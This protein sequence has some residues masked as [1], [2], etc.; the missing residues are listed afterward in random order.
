M[1]VRKQPEYVLSCAEILH[2]ATIR[3]HVKPNFPVPL[4]SPGIV[5]LSAPLKEFL[6]SGPVVAHAGWPPERQRVA[7]IERFDEMAEAR[8]RLYFE[9]CVAPRPSAGRLVSMV[10]HKL[11]PAKILVD[12]QAISY[13]LAQAT[14]RLFSPATSYAVVPQLVKAMLANAQAGLCSVEDEDI[15]SLHRC[16]LITTEIQAPLLLAAKLESMLKRMELLAQKRL[17]R[18]RKG[19]DDKTIQG[20]LTAVARIRAAKHTSV[21]LFAAYAAAAEEEIAVRAAYSDIMSAIS[22]DL[23]ALYALEDAI[24]EGVDNVVEA[25][26]RADAFDQKVAEVQR[27]LKFTEDYKSAETLC[28]FTSFATGVHAYMAKNFVILGEYG[29]HMV[30]LTREQ[31]KQSVMLLKEAAACAVAQWYAGGIELVSA[32]KSCM[33]YTWSAMSRASYDE[34]NYVTVLQREWESFAVAH[35]GDPH[36]PAFDFSKHGNYGHYIQAWDN[37]AVVKGAR[38]VERAKAIRTLPQFCFEPLTVMNEHARCLAIVENQPDF[39]PQAETLTPALR[40]VIALYHRSLKGEMPKC[41]MDAVAQLDETDQSLVAAGDP[42]DLGHYRGIRWAGEGADWYTELD[43]AIKD[44][45]NVPPYDSMVTQDGAFQALSPQESREILYYVDH[46][47]AKEHEAFKASLLRGALGTLPVR[48]T[49]KPEQ[50]EGGRMIHMEC[51]PVRRANSIIQGNVLPVSQVF[52]GS[53]MGRSGAAKLQTMEKALSY[54]HAARSSGLGVLFVQTDFKKFGHSIQRDLTQLVLSEMAAYFAQPWMARFTDVLAKEV[55]A[56]TYGGSTVQFDNPKMADGQGLRNAVW[57]VLLLAIVYGS[58]AELKR[59]VPELSPSHPVAPLFFMDDH[60]LVFVY[61]KTPGM[62]PGQETEA[63][64]RKIMPVLDRIYNHYHLLLEPAKTLMSDNSFVL[65]GDIYTLT[66][67]HPTPTKGAANGLAPSD[68]PVPSVGDCLADVQSSMMSAVNTGTHPTK[69]WCVALIFAAIRIWDFSPTIASGFAELIAAILFM[70]REHGGFAFPLPQHLNIGTNFVKDIDAMWLEWAGMSSGSLMGRLM[71][72]ILGAPSP[73]SAQQRSS[74]VERVNNACTTS[75]LERKLMKEMAGKLSANI[76]EM[77]KDRDAQVHDLC[78]RVKECPPTL[79]AFAAGLHPVSVLI[80]KLRKVGKN[81]TMRAL[82]PRA[83]IPRLR[84][85][86]RQK[87]ASHLKGMQA[88]IKETPEKQI[89]FMG[90]LRWAHHANVHLPVTCPTRYFALPVLPGQVYG[91]HYIQLRTKE[92]QSSAMFVIG[93]APQPAPVSVFPMPT[94]GHISRIVNMHNGMYGHSSEFGEAARPLNARL[95]AIA[96][97]TYDPGAFRP[98]GN[99]VVYRD[100]P[101]LQYST[102]ATAAWVGPTLATYGLFHTDAGEI[103]RRHDCHYNYNLVML[104]ALMQTRTSDTFLMGRAALWK[105]PDITIADPGKPRDRFSEADPKVYAAAR[106]INEKKQVRSMTAKEAEDKQ[107]RVS[108]MMVIESRIHLDAARRLKEMAKE[109]ALDNHPFVAEQR[110]FEVV[111][112]T[113]VAELAEVKPR[114]ASRMLF[115]SWVNAVYMTLLDKGVNVQAALRVFPKVFNSYNIHDWRTQELLA[116]LQPQEELIEYMVATARKCRVYDSMLNWLLRMWASLIRGPIPREGLTL[117]GALKLSCAKCPGAYLNQMRLCVQHVN[118]GVADGLDSRL[119]HQ[120]LLSW[121]D[122][123]KASYRERAEMWRGISKQTDKTN[124]PRGATAVMRSLVA[125]RLSAMVYKK[126]SEHPDCLKSVELYSAAVN[127]AVQTEAGSWWKKLRQPACE[128]YA[129]LVQLGR[130]GKWE[131]RADALEYAI[132]ELERRLTLTRH[133]LGFDLEMSVLDMNFDPSLHDEALW[134]W[135]GTTDAVTFEGLDALAVQVLLAKDVTPATIG[136]VEKPADWKPED[137]RSIS[138]SM[139]AKKHREYKD[140]INRIAHGLV[141]G[142]LARDKGGRAA[143]VSSDQRP[144]EGRR[145]EPAVPKPAR[146]PKKPPAPNESPPRSP[147]PP[148]KPPPLPAVTIESVNQAIREREAALASLVPSWNRLWDALGQD[149]QDAEAF[150]QRRRDAN[151]EMITS[152]KVPAQNVLDLEELALRLTTRARE[153][154]MARN[155]EILS[156]NTDQPQAE[157][158]GAQPEDADA[159]GAIEENKTATDEQEEEKAE[160]IKEIAQAVDDE[161]T[162]VEDPDPEVSSFEAALADLAADRKAG[163]LD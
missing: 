136:A 50:K 23:D 81:A 64:F 90:L 17:P 155:L 54:A 112:W 34:C 135:A 162:Y 60:V 65:L 71:A 130:H 6:K 103:T 42:L 108:E 45:T 78:S 161:W 47:P 48:L 118:R 27:A 61:R 12:N 52:W 39:T 8:A 145:A 111:D 69:A 82:F 98:T 149:D 76:R 129:G 154:L 18:P 93:S 55:L 122:R 146:P 147:S 106:K 117:A 104:M 163:L 119:Q 41:V 128:T 100:V 63:M 126:L 140:E 33:S 36:P 16:E 49:V 121:A 22:E 150:R 83:R 14:D 28:A 153:R 74:L 89:T 158:R 92:L 5:P 15:Q 58:Y 124:P 107:L 62:L 91:S 38:L 148:R 25:I 105:S 10:M 9:A 79:A 31:V 125:Y 70:P 123:Y 1:A 46:D 156:A 56:A 159:L 19:G 151:F 7:V 94:T 86:E 131:M 142:G 2:Y 132:R 138:N 51:A 114:E 29:G 80:E 110:S 116:S 85:T 43:Y 141:T 26:A 127:V 32:Y 37:F 66:G 24:Y 95:N 160:K 3:S 40:H 139:K 102:S 68:L 13:V 87:W 4:L 44:S 11:R 134:A 88:W 97:T 99:P 144:G 20:I 21:G 30:C 101:G 75:Q 152:G 73:G 143:V 77:M 120:F 84:R 57:Q 35:H 67:L 96:A 157:V 72:G 109:T 113:L 133:D 115:A 53:L 59:E 137:L